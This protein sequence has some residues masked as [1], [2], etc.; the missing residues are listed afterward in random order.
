MDKSI[1][2]CLCL[3]CAKPFYDSEEHFIKR[4]DK[5]QSSKEICIENISF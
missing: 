2:M 4:E 1:V 5:N 3:V